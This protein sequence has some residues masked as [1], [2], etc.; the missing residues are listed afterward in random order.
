MEPVVAFIFLVYENVKHE[1]NWLTYWNDYTMGKDYFVFAHVKTVTKQ[2]QSFLK[3]GLVPVVETGWCEPGLVDAHLQLISAALK[4]SKNITHLMLV[5][6]ECIPLRTYEEL[7]NELATDPRSRL[8]YKL[9][10]RMFRGRKDMIYHDQWMCINRYDAQL[11]HSKW[12]RNVIDHNKTIWDK[13][14]DQGL[15]LMSCYDEYLVGSVLHQHYGTDLDEAV[16]F[17]MFTYRYFPPGGAS[18]VRWNAKKMIPRLKYMRR[19]FFGRKYNDKAA[20]YINGFIHRHK[21]VNLP[22]ESGRASKREK[23]RRVRRDRS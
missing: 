9:N 20:R 8:N 5:S 14:D 13:L 19:S 3:S 10:H 22:S 2:T 21:D 17:G 18:P 4:S 15:Y 11:V 1:D 7:R 6:G 16:K 23:L 12:G